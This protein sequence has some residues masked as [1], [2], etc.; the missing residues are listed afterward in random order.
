MS[1]LA[2]FVLEVSVDRLPL[3]AKI[4]AQ[5]MGIKGV[6]FRIVISSLYCVGIEQSA[7]VQNCCMA[8]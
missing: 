3:H 7:A 6:A 5:R 4:E 1:E 2:V 8:T